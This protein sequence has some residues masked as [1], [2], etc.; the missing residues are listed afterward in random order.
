[1]VFQM[2]YPQILN[3]KNRLKIL[4]SRPICKS[5]ISSF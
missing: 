2:T 1:M 5:T 3:A 4:L